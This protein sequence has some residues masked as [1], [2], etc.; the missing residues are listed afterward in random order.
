MKT[1]RFETRATKLLNSKT[2]PDMTLAR[3]WI[4]RCVAAAADLYRNE[5]SVVYVA[6]HGMSF[7]TEGGDETEGS[8]DWL[9][10]DVD[11]PIYAEIRCR[12]M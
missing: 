8:A 7:V 11:S 12:D 1:L 6:T 2:F 9:T 4:V 5:G 10:D 3:E